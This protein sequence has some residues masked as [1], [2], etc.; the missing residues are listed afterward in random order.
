MISA[1][2]WAIA[3]TIVTAS[4]HVQGLVTGPSV[5]LLNRR[6]RRAKLSFP[7]LIGG[8]GLVFAACGSSGTTPTGVANSKLLQQAVAST[9][10]APNYSEVLS[11]NSSQGQQSD[12]LTDEAPDRLG[13]YIERGAKRT[14]VYVIGK[15]E[16]QSKPVPNNTP[17]SQVVF[18]SQASQG[19][20]V[21]D[22]AHSYLPDANKTN[23][24]T[25]SGDTY[26]FTLSNQGQPGTFT[27]IVIGQYV[28]KFTLTVSTASVR[29]AISAIGTSPTVTLPARS[30]VGSAPTTDPSP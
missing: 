18:Q 15:T 26:S 13:G 22:P 17:V 8:A 27:Y 19:V 5:T 9:L 20:T 28:S 14:Y 3:T 4:Y 11:E 16:Y 23:Q 29:L 10:S 25:R 2:L 30:K 6:I 24:A 7:A 1:F 21:L 12:H